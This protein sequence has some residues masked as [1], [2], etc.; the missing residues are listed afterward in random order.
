MST[1][2]ELWWLIPA[3]FFTAIITAVSGAGGG[4]LLLGLMG[5]VLTPLAV[6]PLHGAVMLPQNTF[7]GL[8]LIKNADWR[9]IGI[10][11]LGSIVGA[12]AAGPLAVSLPET[13]SKVLLGLGLLYLVW[14]PKLKGS[15]NFPGKTVVLAVV[16]SMVS[17]V[18]G[19]AGVLFSAIRKRD[20]RAKEQIL[21]DQS[22]C[23]MV[24]HGLKVLVFGAYGF[25]FGPYLPLLAAMV[26]MGMA[27]TLMGVYL[28][29]RMNSIWFDHVFKLVVSIL[30][31][32]LLVDAFL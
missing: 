5:A 14:M 26:A 6:V 1:L 20:D 7:R 12:V 25:A 13:L 21:A 30:A 9:F 10:V 17:M 19:A 32:K 4:V 16:T 11:A 24:Q 23:M 31:G 28:L 2:L 8:L 3:T 18:I 15:W 29:K 22:F 27:G